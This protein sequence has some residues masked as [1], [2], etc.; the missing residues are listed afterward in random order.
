M[1]TEIKNTQRAFES[2][3]LHFYSGI[4][5]N[6][7]AQ[8]PASGSSEKLFLRET[9][10][11]IYIYIYIYIHTYSGSDSKERIC[12]NAG[13]MGLSLGWGDPLEKGMDTGIF[14]PREFH[15]QSSLVGFAKSWIGL[16]DY[17]FHFH[18]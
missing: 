18:R 1:L 10:M 14:L 15:G 8:Q 2:C 5:L 16:S 3:E 9:S 12:C 6:T 7:V 13:D 11:E 4:L 17:Q